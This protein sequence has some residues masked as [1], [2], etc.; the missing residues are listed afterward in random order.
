MREQYDFGTD[1][2]NCYRDG[3]PDYMKYWGN[4]QVTPVD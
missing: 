1:Y 4:A 3:D 2:Q